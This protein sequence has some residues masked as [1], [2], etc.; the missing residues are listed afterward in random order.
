MLT[1][2]SARALGLALLWG[3]VAA[4]LIVLGLHVVT[5]RRRPHHA[6]RV[7]VP[8]D[9]DPASLR[10]RC[11]SGQPYALSLGR[12]RLTLHLE[13][14]E[15]LD[16]GYEA[17]IVGGDGRRSSATIDVV[18]YAGTA[19]EA[20]GEEGHA[21]LTVGPGEAIG[22]VAIAHESWF[23]EPMR[24][25]RPGAPMS[26]HVGYDATRLRYKQ[27]FLTD[28]VEVRAPV[29]GPSG[30][31]PEIDEAPVATVDDVSF[32]RFPIV[33]LADKEFVSVL[34]ASKLNLQVYHQALLAMMTQETY[35]RQVGFSFRLRGS[36]ADQDNQFFTSGNADTL[37]DQ[38]QQFGPQLAAPLTSDADSPI[39][40]FHLTSGKDFDGKTIG[41]AF[42][43]GSSGIS[44]HQWPYA[45]THRHFNLMSHELG[46]NFSA[47]HDTATE[48]CESYVGPVCVDKRRSLM[49]PT[50]YGDNT[51]GFD[52]TNRERVLTRWKA[53]Q[54]AR[55]GGSWTDFRTLPTGT[56]SNAPVLASDGNRLCL[57]VCGEYSDAIYANASANGSDW[58]PFQKLES[59]AATA[60][61]PALVF[62]QN[63]FLMAVRA[64][65]A[66]VRF[67]TSSDGLHWSKFTKGPAGTTSTAPSM[68]VYNSKVFLAIRAND[69]SGRIYLAVF[70]G[71]W[72]PLKPLTFG[73]SGGRPTLAVF[74]DRLMMAV[75]TNDWEGK[76]KVSSSPNGT[77]WTP[78]ETV[79]GRTFHA[80]SLT[81][82][83]DRLFVGVRG[84]W[85][86]FNV[87][88]SVS[89]DGKTWSEFF[90]PTPGSTPSAPC[91]VNHQGRAMLFVRGLQNRIHFAQFE[92]AV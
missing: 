1:R 32:H 65:P 88:I 31:P 57:V 78:F 79:G 81:R 49:W 3:A 14:I 21:V 30:P 35:R 24:V 41:L 43:P 39:Q 92:P 63:Q 82:F 20:N 51:N 53:L 85:S 46:H 74:Q 28:A 19:V 15:V 76:V 64:L 89:A 40:I 4:L 69:P 10:D 48:W 61:T 25:Y 87:V 72:S 45:P 84:T 62:F 23:I 36:F 50:Y 42:R 77:D 27:D 66:D 52:S 33:M 37:L 86:T 2:V 6:M 47:D 56:T 29:A 67:S 70:D 80:P 38:V 83:G 90:V 18:T 22:M 73:A 54:R 26:A 9:I 68:A 5:V 44:Q 55:F 60:N 8:L 59:P 34:T 13:P 91:L 7:W 16:S 11:D 12:R 71:T 58:G 17:V 75:R